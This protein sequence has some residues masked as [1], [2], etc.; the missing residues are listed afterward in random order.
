[1]LYRWRKPTCCTIGLYTKQAASHAP[2]VG[3]PLQQAYFLFLGGRADAASCT[4]REPR[5][6][7]GGARRRPCKTLSV[8]F[9][10]LHPRITRAAWG[11]GALPGRRDG[12][13]APYRHYTRQFHTWAGYGRPYAR[14]RGARRVTRAGGARRI[15]RAARW[16]H[17]ALPPLDTANS[18]AGVGCTAHYAGGGDAIMRAGCTPLRGRITCGGRGRGH[19]DGIAGMAPVGITRSASPRP[20]V[21]YPLVFR[22]GAS[23]PAFF[24]LRWPSRYRP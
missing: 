24:P 22:A 6:A 10:P 5:Q 11:H 12:D 16:G 2:F 4:G 15:T 21:V 9:L 8:C 3:H 7:I 1:M 13:I 23:V 17:R 14:G 20:Q 19:A 18:H